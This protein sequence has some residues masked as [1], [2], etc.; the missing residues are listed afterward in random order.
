VRDGDG[1][2]PLCRPHLIAVAELVRAQNQSPVERVFDLFDN[3]LQGKPINKSD[4]IGAVQDAFWGIGGGVAAG[5]HPDLN[6]NGTTDHRHQ[7]SRFR[8][9]PDFRYPDG[10]I[11]GGTQAPPSPEQAQH[12]EE[13]RARKVMGFAQGQK[14]TEDIV[15][16]RKKALARKHHPDHGGSLDKMQRINAAA[17]VL[18]GSLQ[19]G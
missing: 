16:D 19:N 18:L 7:H 10:W 12:D 8:P 4:V 14:L 11:G 6:T 17:D 9:P 15:K 13:R 1:N 5:Y 3:F 2:P